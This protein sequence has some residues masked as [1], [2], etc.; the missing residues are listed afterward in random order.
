[1]CLGL[2]GMA[3]SKNLCPDNNHP[4]M[5]DLGLPSGTK[6]ACCNV[7]AT[8]P[9]NHGG[10]YAWGETYAKTSYSLQNYAYGSSRDNCRHLNYDIAGSG[11]DVARQKWG[12]SWQMPNYL[13]SKELKDKCTYVWTTYKG[14]K[15]ALITGPNRNKIFLPAAG[16]MI[17]KE[18]MMEGYDCQYWLS[19]D[20]STMSVNKA[21][22]NYVNRGFRLEGYPV[23]PIVE[24]SQ[25]MTFKVKDEDGLSSTAKLDMKQ[26]SIT[27][28]GGIPRTISYKHSGAYQRD[29]EGLSETD[30][31]L[32]TTLVLSSKQYSLQSIDQFV[33]DVMDGKYGD[34]CVILVDGMIFYNE[35]FSEKVKIVKAENQEEF[36]NELAKAIKAL[37]DTKSPSKPATTSSQTTASANKP[38]TTTSSQSTASASKPAATT[39]SQATASVSKPATTT[40]SQTTASASK[41]AATTSSQAT[42]TAS[43]P[44]TTSTSKQTDGGDNDDV[45]AITLMDSKSDIIT[46]AFFLNQK[47]IKLYWHKFVDHIYY[48]HFIVDDSNQQLGD[49]IIMSTKL[50]SKRDRQNL[51]KDVSKGK[52]GDCF[53]V[54]NNSVLIYVKDGE[55]GQYEP[56]LEQNLVD[57]IA[58]LK[59]RYR[60]DNN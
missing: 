33:Y 60:R 16:S 18:K 25:T 46:L 13:Q 14:V 47:E 44:A 26:Q 50:P 37:P 20:A 58:A 31:L 57:T 55:K 36:I 11:Y 54:D 59:K 45:L 6:W 38:A 7:G 2:M 56:V 24:N 23:R 28:F 19:S 8:S 49:L 43:K 52:Y 39:S 40:S 53:I 17:A 1:M 10:Y 12:G 29:E 41:P 51:A 30:R 15:G 9:E 34:C 3:Q 21:S 48:K 22:F 5:I 42:A 32:S 35:K 27:L 4:H